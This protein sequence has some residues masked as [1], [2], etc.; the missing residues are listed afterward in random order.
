MVTVADQ[1]VFVAQV[2]YEIGSTFN[3]LP[4]WIC[5]LKVSTQVNA[6]GMRVVT[7]G[8]RTDCPFRS[9]GF[10]CAVLTDY[11]VIPNSCPTKCLIRVVT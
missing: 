10:Y 8:M 11:I 5:I 6:N 7:I 2:P 1:S 9:S 3:L 4:G